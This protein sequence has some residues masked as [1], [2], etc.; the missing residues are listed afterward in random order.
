MP[1]DSKYAKVF[2][3]QDNTFNGNLKYEGKLLNNICYIM[4]LIIYSTKYLK[5]LGSDLTNN[6]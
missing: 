1:Y 6:K 3:Q 4:Y 5:Y 2:T